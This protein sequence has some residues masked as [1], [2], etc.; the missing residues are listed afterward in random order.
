MGKK[1]QQKKEAPPQ[2]VA[3]Q[4][5]YDALPDTL[6]ALAPF[7][8]Y[9]RMGVSLRFASAQELSVSQLAWVMATLKRRVQSCMR[10]LDAYAHA[11]CPR[12]SNMEP[13]FGAQAWPA[14]ERTRRKD[15]VAADARYLF[16]HDDTPVPAG[17]PE[18]PPLGF[19]HY[20]FVVEEDVPVLYVYELQVT[21]TCGKAACARRPLP[22]TR[23]TRSALA[24]R[25]RAEA[26]RGKGLGRF[27]M[28]FVEMLAKRSPGG[29]GGV[30]LTIQRA[31][32]RALDFYVS[33]CRYSM[34]EI[35][36]A[37]T[38]PFAEADEYDYDIF[39]KLFTDEARK[40]LRR[41]GAEARVHN[42]MAA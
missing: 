32:A 31:N 2:A 6:A 24:L 7:A 38:D 13:V 5:A 12:R 25:H 28:L 35:S 15:A 20:R 30:M 42:A 33:K 11:L 21:G 17:A 40:T 14:Q 26:A 41:R 23:L 29:I 27:L 39:S 3:V 10:T 16:A 4:A 18:P 8:T 37:K 22:A 9:K 19:V 34:D 36:P 1:A